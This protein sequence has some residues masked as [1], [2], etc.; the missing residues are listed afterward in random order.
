MHYFDSNFFVSSLNNPTASE[1][2][3]VLVRF[4]RRYAL[5]VKY[6]NGKNDNVKFFRKNMVID[7]SVN[8]Y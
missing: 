8:F 7:Q 4:L 1:N 2:L 5:K 3:F 6:E